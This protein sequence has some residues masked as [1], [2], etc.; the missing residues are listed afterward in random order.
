MTSKAKRTKQR[1]SAIHVDA[2]ADESFDNHG[3]QTTSASASNP[4]VS[5]RQ[6][7][8]NY[9]QHLNDRLAG[10]IERV[11]NLETENN[12]L[13]VQ[14]NEVEVVERREK[15][16][17]A[18]RYEVKIDDLRKQ[19]DYLTREKAKLQIENDKAISGYEELK[20]RVPQLERDLKKSEKD[21]YL[22][23]AEIQDLTARLNNADSG[24]VQLAEQNDKLKNELYNAE[25]QI[26]LLRRQLEDEVLL[27][28]ELENRLQTMKEDLDFARRSH[29]NQI[30]EM[31]RK[32]QVEMTH[33]GQEVQNRYEAKL[34]EQL[35]A[36]RADFDRRMGDQRNEID[37]LYRAKLI[38]A[39]NQA[40]KQRE[41][42]ARAREEAMSF[43]AQLRELEKST[44]DHQG[45]V[46]SLNRR[47][48]ELEAM[49]RRAHED[50]DIR[51]QQR[52]EQIA[53]MQKEIA[54]LISDYQDLLDL[55]V[56]LDTELNAYHQMLEQEEAR[57]HITP[58][59]S[60]NTTAQNLNVSTGPQTRS[61]TS[62][63]QMSQPA[64]NESYTSSTTR[65]GV[66]RRRLNQED[67][68]SFDQTAK[69]WKSNSHAEG[70]VIID[71]VDTEGKFIRITN[72]SEEDMPIVNWMIK[73]T[74][75]DREVSFKFHSRAKIMAG[76]SITIYSNDSGAEHQ[77]PFNILMKNQRWPQG[78]AIRT[79]LLNGDREMVAWRESIL[80]HSFHGIE[81][82]SEQ[83]KNCSIM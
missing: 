25:K 81:E 15:E 14:V 43:G 18:A 79:E 40:N 27:R 48:K 64:F 1:E 61:S 20:A 30:E 68:V 8:K 33:Y 29:D 70:D 56:K 54:D 16:N 31:R 63:Q 78:D 9:L 12:R 42:A 19:V 74:A 28:T 45:I 23:Q 49:L 51:L 55:K 73:S 46:D 71:E 60:P 58:S 72:K 6:Q 39:N 4:N 11:R 37:E 52:D 41:A 76:K 75:G 83:D 44:K 22:A 65:R 2:S 35:N 13:Q 57:L 77:P 67:F 38:E 26:E 82:G 66:K 34:Q 21:K 36:M 59:G 17:L 80:Q 53:Q 24:R 7:E 3:S 69:S 10:Y 47:V 5:I 62:H 32:R 50:A